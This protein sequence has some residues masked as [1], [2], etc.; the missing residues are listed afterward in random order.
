MLVVMLLI[1]GGD[2]PTLGAKYL[3]SVGLIK[4]VSPQPIQQTIGK[5]DVSIRKKG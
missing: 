5:N 2:C 1:R 3:I 4:A